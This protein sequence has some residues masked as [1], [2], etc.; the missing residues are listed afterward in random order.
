ML[1]DIKEKQL[2]LLVIF[3]VRG[4]IIFVWLSS[5]RF[6]VRRLISC[7]FFGAVFILVFE[8]SI[9]YAFYDYIFGNKLFEFGFVMEYRGFSI[10]GN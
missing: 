1:R 4:G 3:I 6:V 8:F 9:Y 5:F 2:L 10:Y 7:C